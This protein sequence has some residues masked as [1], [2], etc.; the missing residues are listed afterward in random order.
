MRVVAGTA[1]GRRLGAPAGRDVRPTADRVRQALF[2]ALDSLGGVRQARVLD[3]FAGTGALGIE[4][5]SRGAAHATFVEKDRRAA[6][7]VRANLAATGFDDPGR[8]RV[9][10]ADAERF[11]AGEAAPEE[12]YG[13]TLLDPPYGFDRWAPLLD[14]L[15]GHLLDAAYVVVESDRAPARPQWAELARTKTYGSTVV[16]ILRCSP[17]PDLGD[18]A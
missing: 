15:R 16:D 12:R 14:A 11:V 1:R 3:L 6:N 18:Q 9:I 2:N 4:A 5:L 10:V 13:L 17:A 7:V 8:S